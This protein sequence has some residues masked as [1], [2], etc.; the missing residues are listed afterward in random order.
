MRDAEHGVC[1]AEAVHQHV[2]GVGSNLGDLA[3]NVEQLQSQCFMLLLD[4]GF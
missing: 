2:R 4:L 1:F 3:L